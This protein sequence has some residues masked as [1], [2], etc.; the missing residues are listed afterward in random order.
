MIC[1][2]CEKLT[3]GKCDWHNTEGS[4]RISYDHI[5]DIVKLNDVIYTRKEETWLS[6]LIK[7]LCQ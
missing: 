4:M 2:E 7:K 1:K 6:K 3:S 5:R